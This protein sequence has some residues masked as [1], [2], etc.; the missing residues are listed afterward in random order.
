[1]LSGCPGR[2]GFEETNTAVKSAQRDRRA[3]KS[4]FFRIIYV[5]VKFKP[6]KVIKQVQLPTMRWSSG[7]YRRAFLGFLIN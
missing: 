1:M 7:Y 6:W 2:C 3:R 5:I 4:R